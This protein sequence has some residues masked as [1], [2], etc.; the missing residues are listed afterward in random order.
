MAN[1]SLEQ[2][3][4]ESLWV[5]KYSGWR[6]VCTYDKINH[7]NPDIR[8]I[9]TAAKQPEHLQPFFD[10][11]QEYSDKHGWIT[12]PEFYPIWVEQQGV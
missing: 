5:V 3:L 7:D 8:D 1:L 4:T 2:I 11:M 10:A 12:I 9:D 6:D